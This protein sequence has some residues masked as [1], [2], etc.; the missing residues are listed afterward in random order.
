MPKL[1]AALLCAFAAAHAQRPLPAAGTISGVV[2]DAGSGA[3]IPNASVEASGWSASGGPTPSAIT[4]VEGRYKLFNLPPGRVS[5]KV[6]VAAGTAR[7]SVTLGA[8]QDVTGIA[9]APSLRGII[10]GKVVDEF[11]DR[12][13]GVCVTAINRT[14]RQGVLQSIYHGSVGITNDKGEYRI[15]VPSGAAVL[16]LAQ[17]N[18]AATADVGAIQR[19]LRP[20]AEAPYDPKLRK[21][22]LAPSYYPGANSVDGAEAITLRS[23]EVRE[24]VDIRITRGPSY[25]AEGT[26]E[27]N[28]APA[29]MGFWF[30]AARVHQGY[31]TYNPEPM[32]RTGLDG[33]FR[34][35]DLSPGE[36]TVSA[37]HDSPGPRIP[38]N[39]SLTFR[40]ADKD[41]SNL[42]VVVHPSADLTGEIAWDVTNPAPQVEV[43]MMLY[44]LAG[45]A[46]SSV[47]AAAPGSF[48]IEGIPPQDYE[49][50][51][52]ARPPGFDT[53]TTSF[54][55]KE[56]TYGG[57][58]VLHELMHMGAAMGNDGLHVLV[59]NDGASLSG[60]LADRDGGGV[61][62][63]YIV[64]LPAAAETASAIAKSMLTTDTDQNGA[65][66]WDTL[67]PGKY[68]AMAM[69]TAPVL[70]PEFMARVIQ[71]R[72]EAT[73][74][75][76]APKSAV[77]LRLVPLAGSSVR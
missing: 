54:Y 52:Y 8:G 34:I 24:G 59:A 75:E 18:G 14:Y 73:P 36:Y 3:P 9:L 20:I 48:K 71:M 32:A 44:P 29:A 65:F 22:L 53:K 74:V 37:H 1:L 67:P 19:G 6:T 13:T 10:A 17:Q 25:C 39:G 5:V 30:S 50:R 28:G 66:G 70:T 4:D 23:G 26:I 62:D 61:Q 58:S 69:H 45:A 63:S 27:W 12:V 68:L 56:V 49:V 60:R 41:V 76:L 47:R 51:A 55:V 57:A 42:S 31:G 16:V 46:V 2:K 7:R 40:I 33:R 35:C 72:S 64:L 11:N 43:L 77:N 38:D 15:R 21:Q